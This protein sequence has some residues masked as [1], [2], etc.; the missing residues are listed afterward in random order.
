MVKK[1]IENIFEINIAK[2]TSTPMAAY[3]NALMNRQYD[4]ALIEYEKLSL[5]KNIF[6]VFL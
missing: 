2:N 5:I 3:I 4:L 1:N 6:Q